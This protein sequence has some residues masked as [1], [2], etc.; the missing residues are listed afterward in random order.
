MHRQNDKT[1][2]CEHQ[3]RINDCDATQIALETWTVSD[4]TSRLNATPSLGEEIN[5][6]VADFLDLFPEDSAL[7]LLKI[8]N[9]SIKMINI[10][11]FFSF[12]DF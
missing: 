10:Y 12:Q 6:S 9:F 3:K 11:I 5:S 8:L 7:G 2:I 1:F 4:C